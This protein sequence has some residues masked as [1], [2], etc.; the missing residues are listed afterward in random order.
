MKPSIALALP[1]LTLT[2][3]I[4]AAPASASEP[5]DPL[6]TPEGAI[7]MGPQIGPG[8]GS[9][10][11]DERPQHLGDKILFVNFDG[12][13][14]NAC[15]NNNPQN[16]CS[17]IFNGTVLPFSGTDVQQA[18]IIQ[19]IRK[20]VQDFGITVT[21]VRPASGDY[22]MEMVGN[23]QGADPSFAGVA[24][25]IDCFDNAGGETSFTLEA[26]GSADG[27]AEIVLQELAH[28]WGLEHIDDQSDLLYPTTQGSNKTFRDECIKI[29]SDTDL[30]PSN[31]ICNSV[32]TQFCDFGWQNSYQEM[33]YLF[34]PSV[35]D[36]APPSVSI[37]NPSNGENIE[38]GDLELIISLV[39]DQT[40]AVIG[41]EIVIDGDALPEPLEAGGA[42]AAPGELT[43]PIEGLPDGN[44]TVRVD[45]EDES[46][47]PASDEVSFT[48]VGNPQGGGED[49]GGADESG[50]GEGAD[51]AG[52]GGT[53]GDAGGG[54][55]GNADGSGGD[56]AG[57]ADPG[58]PT[59]DGCDCR[60][61]GGHGPGTA[62]GLLGLLGLVIRR[63]R[64]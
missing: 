17:T 64:D 36:T 24:P 41:A 15:G 5:V 16:N 61:D 62:L 20:R 48:V 19:V 22:D 42:Y 43:F 54:D 12:A 32:H 56:D 21:N 31:G 26:S 57:I 63:R 37:V 7:P 23:W 34:G 8:P 35:A 9:L 2:L 27:I 60:T 3:A 55:G 25:N 44:Y 11:S 10:V 52:G 18:S 4:G 47:N 59:N 58:Q 13:D 1:L 51:D 14:M 6:D 40:P 49:G 29:V 38:G 50:G 28:T 45:I 46:D 33:L 30:N 39:D 53:G